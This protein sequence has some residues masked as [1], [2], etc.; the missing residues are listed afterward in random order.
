[1]SVKKTVCFTITKGSIFLHDRNEYLYVLNL[2]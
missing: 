2:L 1:M